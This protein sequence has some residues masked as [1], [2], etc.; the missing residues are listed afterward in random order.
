MKIFFLLLI[1]L[2]ISNNIICQEEEQKE[3]KNLVF[4][5]EEILILKDETYENSIKENENLFVLAYAP[6]CHYCKDFKP[7]YLELNKK[8]KELNLNYKI[9]VIDATVNTKFSHEYNIQSYP[10]MIFFVKKGEDVFVYNSQ[11][12]VE[13]ILRFMH[14]KVFRSYEIFNNVNE[15]E[16]F[17]NDNQ[18]L[19]ISSFPNDSK[20]NKIFIDLSKENNDL[21]FGICNSEECINKYNKD[22]ILFTNY[23]EPI[24]KLKEIN[25]LKSKEISIDLLKKFLSS[26][27]FKVGDM[28]NDKYIDFIFDNNISSIFYVRN[29]SNETQTSNDKLIIELGKMLRQKYAFFTLDYEGENTN[30]FK[31]TNEFFSISKH[32]LPLIIYLRIITEEDTPI[33]KL[34][35]FKELTK[36]LI[37]KFVNDCNDGKILNALESEDI[38]EEKYESETGLRLIYGKTFDKEVIENNKNV[39]LFGLIPED[40]KSEKIGDIADNISSVYKNHSDIDFVIINIAKNKI[41]YVSEED[42]NKPPLIFLYLRDKK[43]KPIKYLGEINEMKLTKWMAVKMGWQEYDA[44]VDEIVKDE[45]EDKKEKLKKYPFLEDL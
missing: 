13:S 35:K 25:F 20:E 30:F 33:Y 1:L 4:K 16:K 8:V 27:S 24:V 28:F 18:M 34:E 31:K 2:I 32:D 15:V 22:F 37:M 6:W 14:K 40:E 11:R 3:E 36:Y 44:S 19:L 7:T 26:F 38:P 45:E 10:S 23:D 41:R 9:S 39:L 17:Y 12:N 42:L 21:Y 29:S 43:D 5:E